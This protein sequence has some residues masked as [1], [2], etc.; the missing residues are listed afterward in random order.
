MAVV[1]CKMLVF[2]FLPFFNLGAHIRWLQNQCTSLKAALDPQISSR[3]V[4]AMLS[5]QKSEASLETQ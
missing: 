4:P 2:L 1:L 3:P 5:W